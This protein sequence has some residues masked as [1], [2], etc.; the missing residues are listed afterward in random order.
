MIS[1]GYLG[2]IMIEFRSQKAHDLNMSERMLVIT[3]CSFA[4]SE[5]EC[6]PS[7]KELARVSGGSVATI[8]RLLKSLQDKGYIIIEN[9]RS[10]HGDLTTSL[11][12]INIQKAEPKTDR[13]VVNISGHRTTAEKLFDRSW[14]ESE[15][16]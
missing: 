15:A 16:V 4:N 3:L 6:F 13:K 11:Y 12:R 2:G 14:D 1:Y 8:K 5:G 9:R 10:K 7:H